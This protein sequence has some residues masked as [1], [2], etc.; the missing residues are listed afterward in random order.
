[1]L[2]FA[3]S[4]LAL[5]STAFISLPANAQY[6]RQWNN[7]PQ[8]AD[9]APGYTSSA[10]NFDFYVLSLSWSSGFCDNGGDNHAGAQCS[11]GSNLG[12]VVH[13]LW[14][15]YTHGF[16]Q[17]CGPDNRSPSRAALEGTVGVYPDIGLA[18][19]E[20]KKHGTCSG[21]SPEGYFAD[22]RAA[23]DAIVIPS[24][25]QKPR[26]AQ[27]FD[28]REI[29]RAF[30]EN[31]RGLRADMM[32]IGCP[33]GALQEIRICFTKDLRGFATCPDVARQSCRSQVINVAPVR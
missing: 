9:P 2:K 22:V 24:N 26:E 3:L 12:F 29:I 33:R 25:L 15:Q 19:Y 5:L 17:N 20:W 32:S 6:Y 30:G 1:M 21:K 10:G 11:I 13:G 23:R 28:P 4:A 8:S 7:R 31:N 14:P 27:Q 16:P 18:R